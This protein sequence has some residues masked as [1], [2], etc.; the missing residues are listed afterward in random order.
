MSS[1]VGFDRK[2][3]GEWLNAVADRAAQEAE[4]ADLRAFL[5][6]LLEKDHP[7]EAA[8]KKSV[9][10]VMRIW[11]V[12]PQEHRPL[13]QRAFELLRE[14]PARDRLWLHWGMSQLAYP[15]FRDTATAIGRLLKLQDEFTLAQLHRRLI[16]DWGQR[17]TVNRAYQRVVRSMVDW[18][19]L[20]DTNRPGHFHAPSKIK[21]K[22]KPLQMWL[23]Q[24]M[25][26]ANGKESIEAGELLALPA[27]FPF[28]L[29]PTKTDLRRSKQFIVH[30]QGLDMDMVSVPPPKTNAKPK[31]K[32]SRKKPEP[33]HKQL[34]L[35]DDE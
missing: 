10:V 28:K 17:T 11:V 22:S 20:D 6:D 25:H 34:T 2:I 27:S 31:K 8:R 4:P 29:T 13:Q 18:H 1:L 9:G 30:R 14:I 3:K 24:A 32:R 21:T 23:L 7:G 12:V 5:H 15:L 35:L 33:K 26:V 16:D 19:A